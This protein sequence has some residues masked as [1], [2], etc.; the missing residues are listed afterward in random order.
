ME[1][2]SIYTSEHPIP[3]YIGILMN[4]QVAL[5]VVWDA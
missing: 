1:R 2:I 3:G 5:D 4:I